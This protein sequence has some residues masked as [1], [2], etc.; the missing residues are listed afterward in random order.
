MRMMPCAAAVKLMLTV[1]ARPV[2]G[3]ADIAGALTHKG[4]HH[5]WQGCPGSKVDSAPKHHDPGGWHHAASLDQVHWEDRGLGPIELQESYEGM[6]SLESPCSGFVTVDDDGTPCAGFRQC[7]ST[8]GTTGLNPA[9]QPW[10]VPLELR[11][12]EDDNLTK[13][14]APEYIFPFYYN[15]KLPYDPTR[16][17]IDTDGKWY[18]TISTDGCNT[19]FANRGT[20]AAGGALQLYTSPKLRGAGANWTYVSPMIVTNKTPL[21]DSVTAEFVTSGYFGNVPGDPRGGLTRVVTNN[22][23]KANG[24]SPIFY[25]GLQANGSKFL[26]AAGKNDFEGLGEIGMLDWGAFAPNGLAGAK[27]VK[28]LKGGQRA[29]LSMART[30]G[31]DPNQV[32]KPGRRTLVG[33]GGAVYTFQTLLQDITLGRSGG[34]VVLRQQ[35][36]PEL[37]MLRQQGLP[38]SVTSSQQFEVV[39]TISWPSAPTKVFFTVFNSVRIGVDFATE[40]AYVDTGAASSEGELS[41]GS[42]PPPPQPIHAGPLYGEPGVAVHVHAI[43]DHCIVAVIF[44]NRTSLTVAVA[45]GEHDTGLNVTEGGGVT[46]EAWALAT[47]NENTQKT[48]QTPWMLPKIHNSP[49]C[50]KLDDEAAVDDAAPVRRLVPA[51]ALSLDCGGCSKTA[52]L[53]IDATTWMTTPFITHGGRAGPRPRTEVSSSTGFTPRPPPC[54][55]PVMDALAMAS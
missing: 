26:D 54:R 24:G 30:L 36:I 14:S 27:G 52:P 17:W 15:R 20:C 34:A 6:A 43:V 7:G 22:G 32:A 53:R 38:H 13:W 29:G 39:A 33:W 49:A 1:I 10:D 37:Q 8:H 18:A 41:A 40:L 3:W 46:A 47:A 55:R 4:T 25:L 21:D 51:P 12:A 16:P 11:C 45:P 31:S 19:S 28:A 5:V 50:L 23:G 2:A 44:N 48:P 9:A 35:F 42:P